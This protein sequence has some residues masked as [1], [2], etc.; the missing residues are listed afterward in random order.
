MESH[1]DMGEEGL[2]SSG[3]RRFRKSSQR[4]SSLKGISG[5]HQAK[6]SGKGTTVEAHRKPQSLAHPSRCTCGHVV[7]SVRVEQERNSGQ[8]I[9]GL[10]M[11]SRG[12]EAIPR[13]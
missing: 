11:V 9:R 6:R 5:V 10:E 3:G 13:K 12:L 2:H 4:R 1:E 8:L 7:R